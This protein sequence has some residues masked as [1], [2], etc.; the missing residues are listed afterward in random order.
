MSELLTVTREPLNFEQLQYAE[1]STQSTAAA[2]G[3][4]PSRG[5]FQ[6][7]DNGAGYGRTSVDAGSGTELS[8]EPDVRNIRANIVIIQ[9]TATGLLAS[10][11]SGM[12]NVCIPR[13]AIDLEIAPQLYFW[14]VTIAY[15]RI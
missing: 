8:I 12:I 3:T 7:Q 10:I 13:M 1:P 4:R 6:I 14:L 11:C 15:L 2:N 5:I 9:L